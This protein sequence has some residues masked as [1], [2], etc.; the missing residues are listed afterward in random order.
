MLFKKKENHTEG[1][2]FRSLVSLAIP[3]ILANIFQTAYQLIDTF[4]L[5]RLGA[6]A[7]AAVSI[8]FPLLFL[9]LSVGGGLTLAGTV[10]VSHYKRAE[11]QRMVNYS[12][13]QTMI[14]IIAVSK[15]GRA[16]V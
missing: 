3:I 13:S 10:I 11:N 1:S 9:V 8:S 16:H 15:I 12:S 6:N 2:I 14:L 4:W 5:G 7:V